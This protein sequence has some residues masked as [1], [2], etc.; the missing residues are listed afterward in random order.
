[1]KTANSER[2]HQYLELVQKRKNCGDCEYLKNPSRCRE[3]AYDNSGH[4]GPWTQWQ[5]N[6]NAE[7]MV[8]GQDWGRE[9][10]YIKH[11][12]LEKDENA[13]NRAIFELLSSI[14][15]HIRL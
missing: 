12:G 10:Y 15:I 1:M 14:G 11:K 9:G 6:L 13:T 7:V 3:G 4:I 5:G 8:I 2:R